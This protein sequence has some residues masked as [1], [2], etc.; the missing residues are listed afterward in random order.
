MH[1]QLGYL[2]GY[3]AKSGGMDDKQLKKMMWANMWGGPLISASMGTHYINK[4]KR[5]EE[6]ARKRR[7]KAKKAAGLQADKEPAEVWQAG[8]KD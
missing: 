8:E 7:A 1:A 2:D 5:E 6:E 4:N 3:M